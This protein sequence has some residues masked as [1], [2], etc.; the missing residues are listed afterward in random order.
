MTWAIGDLQ[1][2]FSSFI[3]LLEKIEFDN[4]SDTIWLVGD[5]V[6]R[7]EASLRTLEY[8]YSNK[9]RFKIVLGNHDISLIAAYYGIKKSN[10][11][12]EPILKSKNAQVLIEWLKSQPFLYID[13]KIGYCMAHAGVSPLFDID[14]AKQWANLITKKLNSDGYID[15]LKKI[16][17]TKLETISYEDGDD[18]ELY[19]LSSFIA[20]RYCFNN[21]T[22]EL[23][24]KEAYS[25]N[26]MLK[27]WFQIENRKY[28]PYKIIFGHWST[29]GF[30]KDKNVVAIDTGCVWGGKLTAFCLETQEVKSVFCKD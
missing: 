30:Y 2:C 17:K 1:G 20:M 14:E 10:P 24:E 13:E 28:I 11:T 7:G 12:I 4:S 25:D 23:K 5:L 6:N 3:K 26:N 29:L 8:I 16:S 27:P 21:G 9:D 22:F 15:F 18:N 19:A